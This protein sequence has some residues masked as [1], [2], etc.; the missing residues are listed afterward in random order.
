MA[1]CD[2]KYIFIVIDISS[3]NSTMIVVFSRCS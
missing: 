3:Y 1:I 2:A